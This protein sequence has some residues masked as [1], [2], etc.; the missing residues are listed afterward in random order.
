MLCFH[1]H[2]GLLV[3]LRAIGYGGSVRTHATRTPLGL[4]SPAVPVLDDDL[5]HVPSDTKQITH[6]LQNFPLVIITNVPGLVPLCCVWIPGISS[7]C[8]LTG[9]NRVVV[10]EVQAVV[11]AVVLVIGWHL[12]P[13]SVRV[14]RG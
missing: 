8:V 14:K 4:V 13:T 5:D 1:S 6:K 9:F 2:C 10:P 12:T 7:C 11:T 3:R